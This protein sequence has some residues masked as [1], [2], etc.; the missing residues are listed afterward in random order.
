MVA[1]RART[2]IQGAFGLA[3]LAGAVAML[4]TAALVDGLGRLGPA[5]MGA[6]I[7]VLT[8]EYPLLGLRW[9][10]MARHAVPLSRRE[11]MRRYLLACFL[12]TFTPGQLG[13]DVY[14]YW[15]LKDTAS[16]RAA[17][18]GLLLQERLLGLVS[19]LAFFLACFVAD[20]LSGRPLGEGGWV[21]LVMAGVAGSG[22]AA[23]PLAAPAARLLRHLPVGGRWTAAVI[24]VGEEAA[25]LGPPRRFI[26]L[27]GLS[28]AGGCGLWTL[29]TQVVAWDIG[30]T[31][32]FAALGMAA[33][34]A[35]I[36]RLIPITVQG[37]GVREGAFAFVF[38]ALGYSPA[39]GF[40]IGAVAYA[41]GS[42]SLVLCGVIGRLLPAEADPA[43]TGQRVP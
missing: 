8:V 21:L 12:N 24:A 33:T 27:M 31:A 17:L 35:D 11:Q 10:Y 42:I 37:L 3:L 40:L 18:L 29:G 22:L 4:D 39:E 32:D 26:V 23:L 1:G 16:S 25:R 34:L 13:G 28:L 43:A 7:L 15:S 30:A 20:R 5:A 9:Y 19:Y 36:V 41:A 38:G 6:C 2:L 14:R